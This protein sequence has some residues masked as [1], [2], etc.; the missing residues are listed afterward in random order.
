[1][2]VKEKIKNLDS[3]IVTKNGNVYI[4]KNPDCDIF[5]S[6]K[7]AKEKE[8]ILNTEIRKIEV[9]KGQYADYVAIRL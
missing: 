8:K 7:Y 3:F 5:F 1:M 6:E 9:I 2:L 4:L